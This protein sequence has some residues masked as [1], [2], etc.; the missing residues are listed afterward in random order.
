MDRSGVLTLIS[1]TQEQDSYGVWRNTQTARNVFCQV[2]SVSRSEFFEGGRNGL[3]P[4]LVFTMFRFDYEN[5]RV[6]QFDGV[7]YSIY[8]TYIRRDDNIELYAE[9]RGGIVADIED[10]SGEDDSGGDAI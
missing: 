8:R 5:E 9:K 6:C 2:N 1:E 10:D 3:K 7:T 4:E